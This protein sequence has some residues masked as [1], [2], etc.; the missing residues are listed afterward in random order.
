MPMSATDNFEPVRT[1]PDSDKTKTGETNRKRRKEF[2]ER[3]REPVRSKPGETFL[4]EVSF[5]SD[6]ETV[7]H[8]FEKG[9]KYLVDRLTAESAV[10]AGGKCPKLTSEKKSDTRETRG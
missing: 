6:T 2:D 5:D 4:Y 1:T 7:T 8:K 9:K 3:K 10:K